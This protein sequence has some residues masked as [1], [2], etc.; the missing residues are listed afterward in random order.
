MMRAMSNSQSPSEEVTPEL[1]DP[2]MD[3]GGYIEKRLEPLQSE[4]DRMR[5]TAVMQEQ[6]RRLETVQ[7]FLD[8]KMAPLDVFN[9]RPNLSDDVKA[10]ITYQLFNDPSVT[11]TNWEGVAEERVKEFSSRYGKELTGKRDA[12][13]KAE[14]LTAQ[15]SKN[16]EAAKV[17]PSQGAGTPAPQVPED[18]NFDFN[19]D[20][21]RKN[22]A[23]RD[24]D[25]IFDEEA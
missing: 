11:M 20:T 17:A 2:D 7:S 24:L 12:R 21:Q 10:N 18:P 19:D 25:A 1:P 13:S 9:G 14:K 5:E 6:Q 16:A 15:A 23:L 4:L 3:P 8:E 22:R